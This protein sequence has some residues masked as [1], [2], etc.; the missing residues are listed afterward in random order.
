MKQLPLPMFRNSPITG[1]ET[2]N[3]YQHMLSE[4]ARFEQEI[5]NAL[6]YAE[7]THTYDD[8]V[9]MVLQNRVSFFPLEH[10]FIITE[11]TVYPQTKH[12]NLFLTGGEMLEVLSMQGFME[13]L[14]I[15]EGCSAIVVTGRKGWMK[16][17]AKQGWQYS[18]TT[19]IY[20]VNGNG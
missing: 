19:V 11:V 5:K 17:L 8:I 10:S 9:N 12:L 18:H 13:E 15:K 6:S 4:L 14:A 3:R 20:K 2:L 7:G 1:S 16:V